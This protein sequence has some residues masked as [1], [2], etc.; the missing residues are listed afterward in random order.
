MKK[1]K[2]EFSEKL[3]TKN[4]GLYLLALFSE[5]L[6]IKLLF[7]TNISIKRG[8]TAK[9]QVPDVLTMLIMSIFTGAKHISHLAL[10]RHDEVI[11]TYYNWQDFPDDRTIGRIFKLFTFKHCTELSDIET[12]L[13][14][15]VW[16]RKWFGRITFD[17]DSTVKGVY[18][19]QE[20]AEKG[21]NSKKRGQKSYHPLLCYVA[22]NRE[23]FHNWFRSGSSYTSNGVLEFTKECFSKIPKRVWKIF[24][25]ADS[26]FFSGAFIEYLER[27]KCE[28]L[29]KVKLKNLTSLLLRQKWR[30]VKNTEGTE[31]TT[32][33]HQCNKWNKA[34]NF[35]AVRKI[36]ELPDEKMLIP[37]PKYEYFC[38]VSNCNLTPMK[39]H[40]CY[41]Q[42]ATSENWI[43]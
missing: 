29:I 13:R 11:R 37:I 28:Y 17:M 16:S 10:L 38:Y 35:Y 14:K 20:G 15:K 5:K 6:S 9:Y 42:R 30:K 8:S 7:K 4:A 33:M 12:L 31:T 41:G 26:G 2:I 34:R 36:V 24:V 1:L 3:L 22:E 19:N 32:F 23:C 39:A 18:G 27:N 25:R 21:Y 40:R 43:E